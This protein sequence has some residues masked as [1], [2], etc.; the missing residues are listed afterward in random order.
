[1]DLACQRAQQL[2]AE[3]SANGGIAPNTDMYLLVDQ[4]RRMQRP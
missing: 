2:K 3:L 4:L 1:L